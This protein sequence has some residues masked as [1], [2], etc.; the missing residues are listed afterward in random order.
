MKRNKRNKTKKD[1]TDSADLVSES[2]IVPVE[3]K[4]RN[5]KLFGEEEGGAIH[6]VGMHAHAA[7]HRHSHSHEHG[8]VR[9]IPMVIPTPIASVVGMRKVE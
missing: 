7:H 5:E 2:A 6:I 4:P 9:S 8:D 1:Q 3:P